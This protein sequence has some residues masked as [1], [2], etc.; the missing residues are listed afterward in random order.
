MPD[1]S[2]EDIM[3]QLLQERITNSML[4]KKIELSEAKISKYEE[5]GP[6][7]MYYAL[8]RKSWEIGD[9]LNGLDYA[10]VDLDDAKSKAFERIQKLCESSTKIAEA[11]RTLGGLAGVTGDEQDDIK[12]KRRNTTPETISDVLGSAAGKQD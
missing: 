2:I 3:A 8:S 9:L 12:P 11:V 10:D 5:N 7:K 6:A 4:R 1:E